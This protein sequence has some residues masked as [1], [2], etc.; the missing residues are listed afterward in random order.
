MYLV[1]DP[2]HANIFF[3]STPGLASNIGVVHAM[4]NVLGMP[5]H[6]LP[7]YSEDD[8]GQL[9]NRIPG[10]KTPDEYRVRY[11]HGKAAHHFLAGK[12]GVR[13]GERYMDIL[14]CNINNDTSIGN[15]WKEISDLSAFTQD[16]VFP[17]STESL[18]GSALLSLNPTL[19]ADFWAFE[20]SIPL[21]LKF[22][23][24]LSPAAYR[25]RDKVLGM[26]KR[27]HAY[28]NVS[29]CPSSFPFGC[30]PKLFSTC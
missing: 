2:K 13:L 11:F 15:E 10:S 3:K 8:S 27:W 24:W 25:K 6:V 18:C 23:R 1:G 16:L 20:R 17:A 26:V 12:T 30:S 9:A 28:S 5:S 22:P 21:L 7:L 14:V 19:T 4:K 29:R